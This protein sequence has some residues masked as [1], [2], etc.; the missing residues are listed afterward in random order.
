MFL[1]SYGKNDLTIR[2]DPLS[3]RFYDFTIEYICF[4]TR[5][6]I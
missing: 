6:D 5:L 2:V 3:S 4:G 1:V